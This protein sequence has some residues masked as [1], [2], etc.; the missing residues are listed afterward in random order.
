MVNMNW[1]GTI[2]IVKVVTVKVGR[3]SESGGDNGDNTLI[4][5]NKKEKSKW[6]KSYAKLHHYAQIQMRNCRIEIS[7]RIGINRCCN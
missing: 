1:D 7:T 4:I 3:K 6:I 2:I 5:A